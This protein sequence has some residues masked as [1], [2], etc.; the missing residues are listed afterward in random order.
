MK[1]IIL[2]TLALG[3]CAAT[4]AQIKLPSIFADHMVIQ[5]K[6]RVSFWGKS[7]PGTRLDIRAGW[8]KKS[9]T[10]RVGA[11][12]LWKVRIPTPGAGGPYQIT[13]TDGSDHKEITDVLVG[14]VWLASGQSNMEM[15][16]KGYR[17]QP[18]LHGDSLIASADARP[19][20][21]VF[22]VPKVM[23]MTPRWDCEGKW[24]LSTHEN[25]GDFSAVAYQFAE[26]LQDSLHVPVGLVE[27]YWGGTAVQAWMSRETLKKM[28]GIPLAT[29]LDTV[30]S[31]ETDPENA[32][33]LLYNSMVVPIAPYTLKGVIWYQGES[34]RDHPLR[35]RRLLPAMVASWRRLWQEK[36]LPFYEV[37]IA[38]YG[39]WD[40]GDK[41]YPAI[42]RESQ[43]KAWQ[44]IPHSGMAV[45]LDAGSKKRI[46]PPDKTVVSTRLADWALSR[47]YG[48]KGILPSG[49]VPEK[50]RFH[51]ARAVISFDYAGGG[52]MLRA[53]AHTAFMI[54][55]A[56]HVFYPARAVVSGPHTLTVESPY[57]SHAVS[58]RYGFSNWMIASLF[59]TEG[60][61][62]T[63]FR[64][65][66]WSEVSYGRP[67]KGGSER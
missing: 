27:S 51:G 40:P 52:L 18:V 31:P 49:P 44:Q 1:K 4:R 17:A 53:P 43:L 32:P 46:H 29:R 25:A 57:V 48:R 45:I 28:P 14:E 26:I 34:N 2:A 20:I 16:L 5:Q 37:Q 54:A 55:G 63:S 24:F 38:P 35:Y 9:Y 47:T 7:R 10:V 60:L 39:Y 56:D 23:A 12:S 66:D 64:T 30:K 8:S 6:S 65:D 67:G 42:L 13:F 15:P 59:N 41:R 62:A 22:R 21:R 11:D 33:T 36:A 50:T 58:V 61:P 3:A 19:D